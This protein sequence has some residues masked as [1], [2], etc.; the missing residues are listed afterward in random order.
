[1]SGLIS[2]QGL[3][4]PSNQ[5]N[6]VVMWV[7][8]GRGRAGMY[9]EQENR[10]AWPYTYLCNGLWNQMYGSFPRENV[11]E[12]DKKYVAYEDSAQL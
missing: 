11:C 2:Y 12:R 1:M 4:K 8:Q 5:K 3:T 9:P 10:M 7:K 6:W